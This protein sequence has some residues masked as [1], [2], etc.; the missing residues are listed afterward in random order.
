MPS[1]TTLFDDN[2]HILSKSQ[3]ILAASSLASTFFFCDNS[4]ASTERWLA[5]AL[6]ASSQESVHILKVSCA[7]CSLQLH[8]DDAKETKV[9]LLLSLL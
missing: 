5:L 4:L 7:A 9:L 3:A 2:H 8:Y 6:A 1:I